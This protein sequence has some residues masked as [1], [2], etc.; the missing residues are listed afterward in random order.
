[1]E[2]TEAGVS[3]CHRDDPRV[4]L[5]N[6]LSFVLAS[7]LA[8]A[9]FGPDD[10]PQTA[11]EASRTRLPVLLIPA[12][13]DP[14]REKELL[15]SLTE[16]FERGV[17]QADIA[18]VRPENEDCTTDTCWAELARRQGALAAV[19]LQI[20]VVD[21]DYVIDMSGLST[22]DATLITASNERCGLCG[23]G[24]ANELAQATGSMFANKLRSLL[25]TGSVSIQT[26]PSRAQ[27]FIDGELRGSTPLTL[28][29]ELQPGPHDLRIQAP[30]HATYAQRIV[31]EDGDPLELN[32][33][34]ESLAST[35]GQT[36]A[37]IS[38][39][40]TRR[41]LNVPWIVGWASLSSGLAVAT[42]GAVFVGLDGRDYERRCA[43]EDVDA[44][45]DCRLEYTSEAQGIAMLTVGAVAIGASIPLLVYGAKLRT[46][47]GRV[48]VAVS[49]TLS[50]FRVRGR[51]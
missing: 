16:S 8:A 41:P 50:G 48:D 10:G 38:D 29:S 44:E 1:M 4:I 23:F 2:P 40:A 17:A 26:T 49:P 47:V 18:L 27:V 7:A 31:V 37:A 28:S 39:P 9:T 15:K 30:G 14:P 33:T 36:S 5:E 35:E 12:T 34:L 22:R 32:V 45:G 19:R 46:N 20:K 42:A 24:E 51:F 43:G 13:I 11:V 21:R 25:P 3:F 6:V